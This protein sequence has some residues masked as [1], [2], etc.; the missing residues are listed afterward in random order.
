M[1]TAS[2]P[3]CAHE[4]LRLTLSPKA[5][6][7]FVDILHFTVKTWGQKQLQIYGNEIN[8]MSLAILNNPQ[9]GRQRDDLPSTHRAIT[10]EDHPIVY[11]VRVKDIAVVRLLH[12]RMNIGK[13]ME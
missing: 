6:Q 8:S 7:D 11:R 2:I 1:V 5:H 4:A 12:Q 3:M 10:V 13:Q 9:L